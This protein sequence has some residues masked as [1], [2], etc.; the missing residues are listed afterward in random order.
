MAR[1]NPVGKLAD[2]ALSTLKDPKAAAGKVAGQAKDTA[3]LGRM[4]AEAAGSAVAKAAT[5]KLRKPEQSAGRPAAKPPLRAVPDVNEPGHTQPAPR[6][7]TDS[8]KKQGDALRP[9]AKKAV[10][11]QAAPKKTAAKKSTPS[12]A[13]STSGRPVASPAEV[14]QVVEAKVAQDPKKTAA[15]K[16]PT[17]KAAP[18]KTAAKKAPTKKAAA[19]KAPAKKAPTKKAA[20]D[21]SS[22]GDKLPPRKAPAP[23]GD[24]S[25]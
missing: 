20:A 8:P 14:A 12:K 2:T 11:K 6:R 17:K 9:T 10:P 19:K 3:A 7:S 15:K 21:K 1:R 18:K 24:S 5:K 23:P 22:P 4:V 16:V 13:G 25:S